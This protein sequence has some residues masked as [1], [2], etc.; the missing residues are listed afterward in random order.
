[1]FHKIGS[2]FCELT[3]HT[4]NRPEDDN[5]VICLLVFGFIR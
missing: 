5:I 4:L 2:G 3:S 1:M